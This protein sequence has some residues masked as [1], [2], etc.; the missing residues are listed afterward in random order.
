[1]KFLCIISGCP[2]WA[3]K[4]HIMFFAQQKWTCC[5]K[6]RHVQGKCIYENAATCFQAAVSLS[7]N[8]LWRS[9]QG[10]FLVCKQEHDGENSRKVLCVSPRSCSFAAIRPRMTGLPFPGGQLFQIHGSKLKL[11]PVRDLGQAS[12]LRVTHPVLFLRIGKHTLDLLFSQ[13]VQLCAPILLI[14][15]SIFPHTCSLSPYRRERTTCA[16]SRRGV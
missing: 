6:A 9:G 3:R 15:P 2:A 13:P 14:L 7:K 4:W 12:V 8:L 11:H 10:R 5:S 16:R 1:M